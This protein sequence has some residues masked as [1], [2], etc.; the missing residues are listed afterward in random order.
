ML[1]KILMLSYSYLKVSQRRELKDINL[2]KAN[3]DKLKNLMVDRKL[4]FERGNS[5]F[6]IK[7]VSSNLWDE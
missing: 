7:G 5:K 3:T 6:E 4:L 1:P 2:G